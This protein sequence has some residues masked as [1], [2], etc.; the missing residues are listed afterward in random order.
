[1][2]GGRRASGPPGASAEAISDES[3]H[4]PPLRNVPCTPY[5]LRGDAGM[6]RQGSGRHKGVGNLPFEGLIGDSGTPRAL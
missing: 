5:A 3:Q 1:M 4:L 2:D 6:S